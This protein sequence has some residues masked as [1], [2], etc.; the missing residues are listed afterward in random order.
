MYP[1]ARSL[2]DSRASCLSCWHL[3]AFDRKAIPLFDYLILSTF[4]SYFA[5]CPIIGRNDIW[6]VDSLIKATIYR[7]VDVLFAGVVL[8]LRV[9][10]VDNSQHHHSSLSHHRL[11]FCTGSGISFTAF[12]S[13]PSRAGGGRFRGGFAPIELMLCHC[14]LEMQLENVAVA[15]ALQLEVARRHASPFPL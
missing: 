11:S 2:C 5:S 12:H 3:S 13:L 1:A 6:L 7:I 15:N 9:E 4:L 8:F 14:T 10:V